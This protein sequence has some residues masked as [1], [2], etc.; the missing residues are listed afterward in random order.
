L[1]KEGYSIGEK[2]NY[3]PDFD[4]SSVCFIPDYFMVEPKDIAQEY[5]MVDDIDNNIMPVVFFFIKKT[6]FFKVYD[7]IP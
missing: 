3:G 7:E 1:K 6:E 2:G 5:Q 4:Y